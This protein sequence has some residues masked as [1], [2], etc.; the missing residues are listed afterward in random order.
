MGFACEPDRR[1]RH[2]RRDSEGDRCLWRFGLKFTEEKIKKPGGG[3]EKMKFTVPSNVTCDITITA[4][5]ET[6]GWW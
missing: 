6:R 4:D 3:F 1:A 2:A 5:H